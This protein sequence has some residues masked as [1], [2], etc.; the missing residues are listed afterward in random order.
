[1]QQLV[2]DEVHLWQTVNQQITQK[3]FNQLTIHLI[4]KTW[5]KNE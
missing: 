5:I 4:L 2:T 1:M 3:A